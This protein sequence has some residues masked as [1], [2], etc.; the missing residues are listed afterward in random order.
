MDRRFN[1]ITVARDVF[2]RETPVGRWHLARPLSFIILAGT[3]IKAFVW[4]D[5]SPETLSTSANQKGRAM[6]ASAASSSS[7]SF[8][9]ESKAKVSNAAIR[10]NDA[11]RTSVNQPAA[12]ARDSEQEDGEIFEKSVSSLSGFASPKGEGKW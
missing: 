4:G 11:S 5:R 7:A 8:M 2:E 3:I 9:K 12:D 6:R 1:S 10:Q